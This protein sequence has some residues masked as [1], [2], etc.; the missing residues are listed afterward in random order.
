MFFLRVKKVAIPLCSERGLRLFNYLTEYIQLTA[1]FL[2]Q[3][4]L[5]LELIPIFSYCSRS[6]YEIVFKILP[7][8]SRHFTF[9]LLPPAF[10][11]LQIKIKLLLLQLMRLILLLNQALHMH[12]RNL[13]QLYRI[14]RIR[15]VFHLHIKIH[16]Q[17]PCLSPP[18]CL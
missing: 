10:I 11:Y 5:C 13:M 12:F 14:F 15:Q 7:K 3:H 4:F 2:C 9:R 18:F 16:K 8:R 17:H 1:C 6:Q